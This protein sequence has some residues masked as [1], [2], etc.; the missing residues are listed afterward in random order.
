MKGSWTH[1]SCYKLFKIE[2]LNGITGNK[3][4]QSF[5]LNLQAP[6]IHFWENICQIPK[7]KYSACLPIVFQE[8]MMFHEKVAS[9][10]CYSNNCTSV[11]PQENHSVLGCNKSPFCELPILSYRIQKTCTQRLRVNKLIT[12]IASSW[13]KLAFLFVCFL[14]VWMRVREEYDLQYSLV[15]LV[16]LRLCQQFYRLFLL[17][18]LGKCQYNEHEYHFSVIMKKV[19]TL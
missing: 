17:Y 4:C 5:F 7:S 13:V 11:F 9:L 8:E 12:L 3:K 16:W 15:L 14:S 2:R 1:G 18:H 19:S 6:F 10:A